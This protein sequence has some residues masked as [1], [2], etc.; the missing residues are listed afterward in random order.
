LRFPIDQTNG[1][2]IIVLSMSEPTPMAVP[3]ELEG[4]AGAVP[5]LIEALRDAR[6]AGEAGGSLSER[7]IELVRIGTLVALG[8]P[9]ASFHAHVPRAISAGASPADIW[10]AV[11]AVATLVGVP[12]LLAASPAISAALADAPGT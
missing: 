6:V 7:D 9:D 11:A 2:L 10:G 8:A 12:K 4:L 1:R 3:P 5:G